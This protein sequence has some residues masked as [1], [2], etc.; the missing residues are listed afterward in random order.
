ME[1]RIRTTGQI[2]FEHEFR[3]IHK[4][5]PIPSPITLEIID[6]LGADVILQGP[7]PQVGRY[8]YSYRDGAV[9]IGEQWFTK[10][11]VKDLDAEGI[12][13]RDAEQAKN[14]RQTRDQKL[15]D[16]DWTQ[17]ADSPVDKAAW[18]TYRQALRD[19][20]NAEGF[21]W[22]MTWPQAPNA[23]VTAETPVTQETI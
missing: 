10:Y 5:T 9:Q 1:L 14:V 4:G 20:S 15:K 2:V 18:A 19:L 21:P 8:Q 13:L 16:S 6:Y 3:E 7:S 17:L 12:A 11:T 22:D 23:E